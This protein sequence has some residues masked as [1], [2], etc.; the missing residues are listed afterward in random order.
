[1]SAHAIAAREFEK[2]VL[3]FAE[4]PSDVGW[5]QVTSLPIGVV[6]CSTMLEVSDFLQHNHCDLVVVNLVACAMPALFALAD[7]REVNTDVPVLMLTADRFAS[8]RLR[9]MGCDVQYAGA[10]TCSAEFDEL[11]EGILGGS[12]HTEDDVS[13]DDVSAT[14]SR[15][16]IMSSIQNVRFDEALERVT[17][18]FQPIVSWSERRVCAYEAL[19][20]CQHPA[21]PNP[22]VLFDAANKLDRIHELSGLGRRLVGE[23][24]AS[25]PPDSLMFVNIHVRDLLDD[26]LFDCAAPLAPHAKRVVF[27]LTERASAH[28]IEGVVDRVNALRAMGYRVAVDDLGAGYSGLSVLSMLEPEIVKIDMSLVRDV[29]KSTTR[30][31]VVRSL[32]VLAKDLGAQVICEGI[33]CIEERDVLID[34]GC[35]WFQGYFFAKP[36]PPFVSCRFD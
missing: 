6:R 17:T 24:M 29:H 12:E 18:A 20:R 7:I 31:R 25:A 26:A 9:Q 23:A 19:M 30:Q 28:G 33:E 2:T 34:L 13:P 27:E 15:I 3:V 36:A 11:I 21:F 32:L 35:D 10:P 5:R 4:R 16:R 14:H 22:L 8:S 1:V